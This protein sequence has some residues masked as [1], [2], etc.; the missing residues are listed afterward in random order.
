MIE[1]SCG[2][3]HLQ[4]GQ[5]YC[6]AGT[7]DTLTRTCVCMSNARYDT[8]SNDCRCINGVAPDGR[9]CNEG[10]PAVPTPSPPE[11]DPL[12]IPTIVVGSLAF[13][14]IITATYLFWKSNRNNVV[15]PAP[16]APAAVLLAPAPFG[17]WMTGPA[18]ENPDNGGVDNGRVNTTAGNPAI[19]RTTTSNS[20]SQEEINELMRSNE[21]RMPASGGART[22]LGWV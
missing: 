17:P 3:G 2:Q 6:N 4:D 11:Q 22:E 13:L 10:T 7:Y 20:I 16:P 19:V 1:M 5:C 18:V 8:Q 9:S 12:Y 15:V 14:A 21:V